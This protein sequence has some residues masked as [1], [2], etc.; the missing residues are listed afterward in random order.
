MKILITGCAGFIGWK[1]CEFLLSKP[2]LVPM[3]NSNDSSNSIDC[4]N[5]S[6]SPPVTVI[7]IDNMN[8]YYD[9]RLKEWRLAQLQKFPNFEFH[10]L[11]IENYDALHD[12][13]ASYSPSVIKPDDFNNSNDLSDC[14]DMSDSNNSSNSNSPFFT[15]INLAARTGVRYSSENPFI[16]YTTNIMGNLNLLGLW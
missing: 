3:H 10:Q 7:G 1:V 2:E 6:G 16:Y 5:L 13:F 12:L 11:D 8:D 4:N 15:I 14:N 9:V